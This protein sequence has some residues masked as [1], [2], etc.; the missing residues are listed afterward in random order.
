MYPRHRLLLYELF[1][2]FSIRTKPLYN[3]LKYIIIVMRHTATLYSPLLLGLY[4]I[5]AYATSVQFLLPI[6]SKIIARLLVFFSYYNYYFIYLFFFF[7]VHTIQK[8]INVR[9]S[10]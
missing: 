7:F 8:H 10:E 4:K 1:I 2:Y 3:Q 5:C 9:G 6:V